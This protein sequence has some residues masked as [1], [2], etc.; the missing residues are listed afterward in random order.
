MKKIPTIYVVSILAVFMAA[1]PV[2][3]LAADDGDPVHANKGEV[4]A[5]DSLDIDFSAY[6]ATFIELGADRCIPCKKMQPVMK[7][8]AAEFA[9]S[10]QVV[11]YD[12]WKNPEPGRK[13]GIQLIPTQVFL[14]SQ[15][16][17][18]F[19]HTGFFSKEEITEV[20]NKQGVKK[21]EIT[22]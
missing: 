17:E 6:K 13:Y 5:T 22:K 14:D 19:R 12:V 9:E 16:K 15:G 10:V 11:F 18:F 4:L 21:T 3:P 20:L 2:R 8:I 1:N 7:E